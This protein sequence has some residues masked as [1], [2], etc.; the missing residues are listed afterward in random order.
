MK[1]MSEKTS[2]LERVA[3]SAGNKLAEIPIDPMQCWAFIF[4]EPELPDEV[5]AEMVNVN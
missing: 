1:N 2:L 3:V 4:N 5:I